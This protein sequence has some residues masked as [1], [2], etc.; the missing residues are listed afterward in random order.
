MPADLLDDI[1][2]EVTSISSEFTSDVEGVF[3]THESLEVEI[4]QGALLQLHATVL[5]SVDVLHP[6]VVG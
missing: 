2:M 6:A 3:E 5:S 4:K 1:L